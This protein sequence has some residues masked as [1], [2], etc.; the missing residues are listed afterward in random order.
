[1]ASAFDLSQIP[2][3]FVMAF[4]SLSLIYFLFRRRADVFADFAFSGKE[5]ALLALGSIAGWAV[6]IPVAVFGGTYLTVNVGGTLVPIILIAIWV[7]EKKLRILPAAI[8][9]VLVAI[10]AWR[11]VEFHAETGIVA[12]YPTFFLPVV[13]A[14][15]FALVVSIRKPITGV[16][17]AYASGTLGAL[18]GAD[19]LH[20]TDIRAHFSRASE[21]TIISIGGAGVFDMVFL[22]GTF[23]MALH[24]AVVVSVRRPA[25]TGARSAEYPG[26]PITLRDSRRVDATFRRLGTPNALERALQ[27][28]ALSNLALRDADHARSVRMSW[29]A[30]DSLLREPGA[31]ESLPTDAQRDIQTLYDHY[32][33]AREEPPT[34]RDAGNAN[35]AAK[36]LVAALAPVAK[37]RHALEGVA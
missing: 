24:L 28:I 4:A 13:V 7:K 12:R 6:N 20:V 26:E 32:V 18:V 31:R 27:G 25:T 30:V 36:H 15:V 33:R 29:L 2:W 21:N 35:L 1:M 5:V 14:L 34:L 37:M 8:G 10:T 9:T 19:L 11:I 22:A 17:I 3:S 23:A 16:P